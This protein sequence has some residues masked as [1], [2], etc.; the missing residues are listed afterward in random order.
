MSA[1]R[2][3]AGTLCFLTRVAGPGDDLDGR[4]VTVTGGPRK[5]YGKRGLGW[6]YDVTAPWMVQRFP[7]RDMIAQRVQLIPITPDST[8]DVDGVRE[9]E[10]LTLPAEA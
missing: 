4:V 10:R 3:K 1:G 8:A 6:F 7:G 9:R 2:I 5:C